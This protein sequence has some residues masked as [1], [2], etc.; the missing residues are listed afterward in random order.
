MKMIR[1]TLIIGGV[2]F[3]ALGV[4]V[5]ILL[6]QE[7]RHH[8][9]AKSLEHV[10][11]SHEA[12]FNDLPPTWESD[13][14]QM[15]AAISFNQV[16]ADSSPASAARFLRKLIAENNPLVQTLAF[17]DFKASL[18]YRIG[19]PNGAV[20]FPT[21]GVTPQL[22]KKTY[23]TEPPATPAGVAS[24][25]AIVQFTTGQLAAEE[26]LT[27]FDLGVKPYVY[28][29]H[30]SVICRVPRQI[31]SQVA[32]LPFVRWIGE[33]RPEFKYEAASISDNSSLVYVFPLGK[34]NAAMQQELRH[35]GFEVLS[36]D[37]TA[38]VFVMKNKANAYSAIAELDW[39]KKIAPVHDMAPAAISASFQPRDSRELISSPYV[40]SYRGSGV[41]VGIYDTGIHTGHRAF[42]GRI[43]QGDKDANG[44]GTHVAGII[45]ASDVDG[46]TFQGVAPL[47]RLYALNFNLHNVSDAYTA[48]QKS[49]VGVVNN[50]W[51]FLTSSGLPFY[52]YDAN[53]ELIDSYA[54]DKIIDLQSGAFSKAMALIFIAGNSGLVGSRT[55][56]NP[57]TGKNVLTVGAVDFTV[58]GNAGLGRRPEYSSIGPTQQGRLKPDLV[59][60]G[61]ARGP[62][63]F[64]GSQAQ[65]GVVSANAFGSLNEAQLQWPVND[66][67]VR[68]KGTSMA[69]PHVTGAAALA[70]DY[71]E[72]KGW[73]WTFADLK[74][75]LINHAIP[76]QENDGDPLSG[77]ANTFVGYGLLNALSTIVAFDNEA[78]TLLWGKGYVVEAS[79]VSDDWRFEVPADSKALSAT[80]AYSDLPGETLQDNLDLVLI[81]P[82]G[83]QYKYLLPRNVLAESPLE[84]IVVNSPPPGAWTARVEYKGWLN[85]PLVI[86]TQQYTVVAAVQL[87]TP[88]LGL[89]VSNKNLEAQPGET[90]DLAVNVKNI[91]GTIAAGIAVHLEDVASR[92]SGETNLRKFVGNLVHQDA[93]KAVTFKVGAPLLSG[94]YELTLTAGG[95]NRGLNSV[96]E[97][98][99]VKVNQ[100]PPPP[101][102][103]DFQITKL[104]PQEYQVAKLGEGDRYYVDRF[105]TITKIPLEFQG[106]VWIKTAANDY[107][108]INLNFTFEVNQDGKIYVA[109]DPTLTPPAWLK[110]A[111]TPTGKWIEVENN[112]AGRLNLWEGKFT[113][114]LVTM[115]SNEGTFG[116]MM[117]VVLLRPSAAPQAQ[118]LAT[119]TLPRELSAVSGTKAT[120]PILVSTATNIKLAQFTVEFND[121]VLTYKGVQPGSHA[122][123]FS[124]TVNNADPPFP[125]KTAGTTDNV[126]L[127]IASNNSVFTGLNQQVAVLEFEALPTSQNRTTP[128]AF[129]EDTT[130]TFLRTADQGEIKG[131][132]L[133][134]QGS[135]ITTLPVQY[136]ISGNIRYVMNGQPVSDATLSA[137]SSTGRLYN[138]RSTLAGTYQFPQLPQ[139]TYLLYTSKSSDSRSAITGTD[140]VWILQYLSFTRTLNGDQALAAD[141]VRDDIV[142]GADAL[143]ILRY[144]ALKP[145]SGQTGNWT[146]VPTSAEIVLDRNVSQAFGAFLFGDVDG[147][148]GTNASANIPKVS[149]PA[150]QRP[151]AS[152]LAGGYRIVAHDLWTEAGQRFSVPINIEAAEGQAGDSA[153]LN[154]VVFTVRFDSSLCQY[155]GFEL[156]PLLQ[157]FLAIDHR[158]SDGAVRI[159]L[160]SARAIYSAGQLVRLHFLVKPATDVPAGEKSTR[161]EL[162]DILIDDFLM[163]Y[164]DLATVRIVDPHTVTEI[165]SSFYLFQNYPNPFNGETEIAYAIP[166]IASK[167]VEADARRVELR[168]FDTHGRLIRLFNEKVAAA[169]LHKQRWDGKDTLGQAV[170]SGV[171]FY[172]ITIPAAGFQAQRKMIYLK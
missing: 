80:M 44:H 52:S 30:Y 166:S 60:P 20:L 10:R 113:A 155:D 74:A 138:V 145:N 123:G 21:P 115:G 156:T 41:T 8:S 124:V 164:A 16:M 23:G 84:K 149:T 150:G 31:L 69:A 66:Q 129:D 151:P 87:K 127:Q 116:S 99:T 26:L 63:D 15:L 35:L 135:N 141:V 72:S 18:D 73:D 4:S 165:P 94:L 34:G 103:K 172:T 78:K 37:P 109:Y 169:G 154:A 107:P 114:G 121:A 160:A 122:P 167:P 32:R 100:G 110:S 75:H 85:D 125:P 92:F 147:S 88:A 120:V 158:L 6:S 17:S 70:I 71:W 133:T 68:L 136:S 39:V 142:D 140:A 14:S 144:L 130:H 47:S 40:T 111:Y 105:W 61:G 29:P 64:S 62:S 131:R 101:P 102:P 56:T 89:D 153:T 97:K 126:L 51:F 95:V 161:I 104:Y 106:L 57:G 98:I 162:K 36:Y 65:N 27:F 81:A 46:E 58:D 59:A 159:A 137:L 168:I 91:G 112:S 55:I 5:A 67:Y 53:T 90:I 24:Q 96:S 25:V 19:L 139:D 1:R 157:S 163:T 76:L 79:N 93:A 82:N 2:C 170:A 146:F 48:F 77:Y 45:A 134:F 148:W 13:Q 42:S 9:A 38:N 117:Y 128:L 108:R 11:L 28:L 3:I 83:A 119:L 49:T 171:Y 12:R 86:S 43:V 152:R 132:S 22:L 54:D 143:A 33:Y 118:P 7:K 50:S